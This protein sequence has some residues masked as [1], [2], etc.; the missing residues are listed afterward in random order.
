MAAGYEPVPAATGLAE[1]NPQ[2]NDNSLRTI[3]GKKKLIVLTLL[4]LTGLAAAG[5]YFLQRSERQARFELT[6]FGNID[7][8]QV[9]LAFTQTEHIDR[10]LVEEGARVEQGELL[11]I[12]DLARFQYAVD[13]A[14][15]RLA[16]QQ[17]VLARL[18]NGSRPEEIAKAKADVKAAE[19][20]VV[21]ADKEMRR[22]HR[23]AQKKASSTQS[24]DRARFELAAAR[25]KLKALIELQRLAV[26]GP[27]QEDI[28]EARARLQ[29]E[30]AALK[31]A[32]KN[33]HDAHLYAPHDGFIRDRMLEPGDMAGAEK[34]VFTLALTD[35]IWAR[36]YVGETDLGKLRSGMVADIHSDSFPDHSYRGWIGYISSTA[37]FT[38]KSVETTDLRTSLVYQVRV[39]ACNPRYQ[40]RL[41]MPVTV[42]VKLD[43]S[44]ISGRQ[45]CSR[46]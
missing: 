32:R 26:I 21:Y 34:P 29:A 20:E 40:L 9:D 31:L 46:S 27:R 30:A 41:G 16:A 3:M 8:R 35:P 1:N 38:P 11:A 44:E 23:L 22:R 43:Q 14:E 25:E 28:E 5:W 42:R 10:I 18:V 7:I 17:Q 36:T 45:D 33:W 19:A 12:Q 24:A 2:S 6:L 15:A 39:Y 37:E 13:S 4:L